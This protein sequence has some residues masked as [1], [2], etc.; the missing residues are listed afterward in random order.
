MSN[1]SGACRYRNHFFLPIMVPIC[2]FKK[3]GYFIAADFLGVLDGDER[4]YTRLLSTC[5]HDRQKSIGSNH[6]S[7]NFM[8][9]GMKRK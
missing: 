6:A 2:A 9:V 4:R 7:Q 3:A 8:Q 5:I 1:G